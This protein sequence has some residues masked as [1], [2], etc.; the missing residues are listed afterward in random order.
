[1][2]APIYKS[3]QTKPSLQAQADGN[4]GGAAGPKL[5]HLTKGQ[6]LFKEGEHSRAMY[7]LQKGMIRIF[8]QKGTS[9]IEI[10]T[11]R[12]GAVLG[13]L[14]FLDG[15]ERSASGEALTECELIEISGPTFVATLSKMPDW[16]KLMLKT[17]VSRLRSTSNRVRQLEQASQQYSD[18]KASGAYVYM[19][20]HDVLKVL[21]AVLAAVGIYG[22]KSASGKGLDIPGE[23]LYMFANKAMS[24]PIAKVTDFL[25]V[26]Q[27]LGLSSKFEDGNLEET[28][29]LPDYKLLK[30][31]MEF[32]SEEVGRDANKRTQVTLRGFIIMSMMIKHLAKATADQRGLFGLNVQQIIDIET[33]EG[34]PPFRMEEFPELPNF[35]FCHPLEM[36][37]SGEAMT[38]F[39]KD[40]FIRDYKFQRIIK[41]I[42]AMNEEKAE[43]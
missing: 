37:P 8:K 28:I 6:I 22:K 11:I 38:F 10:D 15:Q 30:E 2:G 40:E 9:R 32:Y 41:A 42:K 3:S 5:V 20:E 4:T 14:A 27:S 16:L 7:L 23:Q 25:E 36:K 33:T 29:N 43:A 18:G 31:F 1:M 12:P 24:V 26:L 17:L 35:G 21:T 19:T 34:R 39:K 13:E